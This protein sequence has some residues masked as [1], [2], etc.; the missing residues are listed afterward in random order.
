MSLEARREAGITEQT[1]RVSVG[2]ENADD[3]VSDMK[4]ALDTISV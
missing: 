3:L 1:I 4:Q 2:I